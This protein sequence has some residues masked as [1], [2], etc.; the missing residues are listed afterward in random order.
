[1]SE[2]RRSIQ[3][4]EGI[5]EVGGSLGVLVRSQGRLVPTPLTKVALRNELRSSSS[6]GLIELQ[7]SEFKPGVNNSLADRLDVPQEVQHCQTMFTLERDGMTYV[8]PAQVLI[9]GLFCTN[10]FKRKFLLTP[11]GFQLFAVLCVRG[12]TVEVRGNGRRIQQNVGGSKASPRSEA[13]LL[14]TLGFKS[15]M[16]MV[17]SVF[18]HALDGRFDVT[19]PHGSAAIS[20]NGTVRGDA[21]LVD[22]VMVNWVEP[23]DA[24]LDGLD[25]LVPQRLH[26]YEWGLS[27]GMKAFGDPGLELGRRGW[28]VSREEWEILRDIHASTLKKAPH[29]DA[30]LKVKFELVLQKFSKQLAWDAVGGDATTGSRVRNYYHSL[31]KDG[32]WERMK[33]YLRQARGL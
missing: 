17:A 22:T 1:M 13:V 33:T 14:W 11:G 30:E 3:W 2:L 18:H 9:A 16:E 10:S 12:A 27:P 20:F 31:L 29:Q 19:L 25:G 5:S 7:F 4:V 26:M 23:C 8:V 32:R 21:M 6:S 24:P 28:R 15:G